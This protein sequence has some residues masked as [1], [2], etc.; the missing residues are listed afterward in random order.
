MKPKGHLFTLLSESEGIGLLDRAGRTD[1]QTEAVKAFAEWFGSAE[2]QAAWGEE[3]D[4]F[5]CNTVAAAKLYPDGIPAIYQISNFALNKVD[6]TDMTY[7][8]YVAA[9]SAEWT[10]ILTNLGFYWKDAADAP[11]EPDW[12]NLDWATLT[13]KAE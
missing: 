4:S 6:G 1:E 10:N 3:F 11:A 9:H 12:D 5:P 2:T 7:A 8:E 13:Q